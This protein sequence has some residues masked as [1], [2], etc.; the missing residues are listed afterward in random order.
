MLAESGTL[1]VTDIKDRGQKLED[2]IDACIKRIR[3]QPMHADVEDVED[4][5]DVGVDVDADA[6][7]AKANDFCV[8]YATVLGMDL[9]VAFDNPG[10]Q[11]E[12]KVRELQKIFEDSLLTRT[13]ATALESE[14][15]R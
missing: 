5:E 12:A 4:A 10:L 3:H 7:I 14:C 13:F 8:A 2:E 1:T 6:L 15:T 11:L 9:G